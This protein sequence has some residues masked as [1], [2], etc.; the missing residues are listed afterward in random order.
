VIIGSHSTYGKGTVQNVFNLDDFVSHSKNSAPTLGSIKITIQKFYRVT[1]GSTQLKGVT[2]DITLPDPYA[3]IPYGEKE[4]KFV[5]AWDEIPAAKYEPWNGTY[6]LNELKSHSE[7][8]VSSN[9]SFQLIQQEAGDFKQRRDNSLYSLNY[10][11]FSGEQNELDE[12]QKKYDV[13]NNDS[14]RVSVSN[15]AVD[16]PKINSDSISVARNAQFIKN[17]KK[18]IYLNEAI[19][20]MDDMI[21]QKS[22]VYNK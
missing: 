5:I 8:R 14:T 3:Q 20:V 12:K 17:L 15:L 21:S 11:K 18:D 16:L 6:N 1:G 2:P 19:N 10:K 9:P 22:L 13:L 7:K 4:D